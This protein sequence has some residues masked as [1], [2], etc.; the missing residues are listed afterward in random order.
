MVESTLGWIV[1][2]GRCVRAY[3]TRHDHHEA[4]IHIA[5]IGLMTR[6]LWSGFFLGA[7]PTTLD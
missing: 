7:L 2:H 5:M 3:E 4:V 6:L 1:K